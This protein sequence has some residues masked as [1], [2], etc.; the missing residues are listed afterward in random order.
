MLAYSLIWMNRNEQ[1]SR[2]VVSIPALRPKRLPFLIACSAQWIVKEEEIRI[3]VF[4]PA[5]P[6]GSFVPCAGQG[7]P[8]A[9]RMKK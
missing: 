8:L 9:M 2:N 7:A 1:P 4:M 5:T 6:T 3:A